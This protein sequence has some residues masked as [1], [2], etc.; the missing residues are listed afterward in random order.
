MQNR[1]R[2]LTEIQAFARGDV[3][4]F[5][6]IYTRYR[7]RVY[8]FAYRMVWVQSIAEEV[9]HDTFLS[10]ITYPERYDP[11]RS[12]M[13]TYLCSITRNR[14]LN[15]FRSNDHVFEEPFDDCVS[16][17]VI[18]ESEMNPLSALIEKELAEK[19]KESISHLPF[20]QREVVL[21]REFQE[22]SYAEISE[23]TGADLNVVKARLHRAR[24]ALARSLSTYM[25]EN[26]GNYEL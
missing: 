25:F 26:G 6:Q 8:G 23:V 2:D 13:I 5:T 15:H 16:T 20:L 10:L 24:S 18:D 3:D 22:L 12:S 21:L 1:K 4:A 17:S 14:I 9:T 19:V 7:D 11:K